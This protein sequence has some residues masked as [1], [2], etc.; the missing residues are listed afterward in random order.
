MV[1]VLITS[2]R[3]TAVM[4]ADEMQ[5]RYRL[6]PRQTHV[7]RLLAEGRSNKEIAAELGAS[8]HT[9]RHHTEQ[10]L[11]KLD[12]HTRAQVALKLRG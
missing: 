4:A 3:P 11:R 2:E 6:T 5:R 7:A 8:E 9:V 12:L 1:M 10:V